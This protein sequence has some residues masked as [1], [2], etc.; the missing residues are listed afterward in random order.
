MRRITEHKRHVSK[1]ERAVTT[2][3]P[4]EDND[5]VLVST[6]GDLVHSVCL[7][8]RARVCLRGCV[9]DVSWCPSG[10]E[11]SERI[12]TAGLWMDVIRTQMTYV[13]PV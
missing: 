10:V 12:E 4:M 13:L 2:C 5:I 6:S 8:A 3:N 1:T 7:C 9:C 11:G